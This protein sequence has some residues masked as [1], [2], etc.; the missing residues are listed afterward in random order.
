[1]QKKLEKLVSSVQMRRPPQASGFRLG[2]T[3]AEFILLRAYFGITDKKPLMR[4]RD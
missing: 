2:S 3:F 4:L 1:M